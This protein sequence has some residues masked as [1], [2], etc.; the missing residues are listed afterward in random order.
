MILHRV[1]LSTINDCVIMISVVGCKDLRVSSSMWY[2][3]DGITVTVGCKVNKMSW[4][5]KCEGAKWV[6]VIGNCT[7]EGRHSLD[8]VL[9]FKQE[10]TLKLC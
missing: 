1:Q 7:L 3:R 9:C 4:N 6:G 5:L 8:V 10:L 2:T